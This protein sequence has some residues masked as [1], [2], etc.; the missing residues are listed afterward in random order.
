V[1]PLSLKLAF[2]YLL[3]LA[4]GDPRWIPHPVR[5]LGWAIDRGE[6]W[7]RAH[8][9]SEGLG[10]A[11]LV[12]MMAG[13]S[14]LLVHGL[15]AAAAHISFGLAALIEVILLYTC[16]STRDLG[17]ESWPVYDALKA[18]RLT[19]ARAKVSMIVGRDTERLDEPEIARATLETIGE[20]AMDGIVA[21]LF[22]A[23]I[24][25]APLACLYKAVNTLDSMVGYRSARY[26]RFGRIPAAVDRWMNVVPAW[27]TAVLI[28]FG[29]QCLGF[30]ARE[31]LRSLRDRRVRQE[32]SFIAEAAMGG[33]LRVGLGGTNTYQGQPVETPP[34]GRPS[35]PLNKERIPEAIR[36]MYA[37]SALGIC[38]ALAVR[39]LLWRS[40][41]PL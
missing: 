6:R 39:F 2:A 35:R 19:E 21:P 17:V 5:G 9:R 41:V 8:L 7:I 23:A 31:G 13:G 29:G 26:L 34:M 18:D 37:A 22:Y 30:S 27:I 12:L 25:G 36:V 38:G 1:D 15:I 28:S 3:D 14:W 33:T 10:G 40:G 20:S 11:L 16:L 24:G 32:N 4:V